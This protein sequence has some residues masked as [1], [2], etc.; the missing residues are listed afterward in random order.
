MNE[1]VHSPLNP[2]NDSIILDEGFIMSSVDNDKRISFFDEAVDKKYSPILRR[3][4]YNQRIKN[5]KEVLLQYKN[6][7]EQVP[8]LRYTFINPKMYQRKNVFVDLHYYYNIFSSKNMYKLDKS[9]DIYFDFICRLIENQSIKNEG[10]NKFSV[11]V[12]LYQNSWPVKEGTY[13]WDYKNN[14]NPLSVITRMMSRNPVKLKQEFSKYDWLFIGENGFFRIDFNTFD[15]KD[16]PR[17]KNAIKV[18]LSRETIIDDDPTESSPK[19]IAAEILDKFEDSQKVSIKKVTGDTEKLTPEDIETRVKAAAISSSN[20]KKKDALVDA[21]NKAAEDSKDID[22]AL[23]KL[24]KSID[25]KQLM[26]DLAEDDNDTSIVKTSATR[27]SRMTKLNDNF[28]NSQFKGRTIRDIIE[29]PKPQEL[30]KTSLKLDS[31]NPEWEDLKFINF[32]KTYD[33]DKD[34]MAIMASLGEKSVKVSIL[35]VETEDTS[36]SED[37]VM[38]YTFKC[39]DELGQ[40]FTLKYDIPKL[41]NN[42]FMRLRGNEKTISGQLMLLPAIKTAEDTVQLVSNYNKI[43]IRRFG[44]GA[45]KSFVIADK[46]I[47]ALNKYT[48]NDIKV[49]SGDNTKICSKYELPVDYID[50]ASVYSKIETN[51]CIIYFNQDEIRK[52]Y[53]DIIDTTKGIPIIYNKSN[54]IIVYYNPSLSEKDISISEFIGYFFE[55]INEFKE[56]YQSI[57]P[58]TKYTYSKASILGNNIPVIVLLGYQLGLTKAMDIANIKYEFVDKLTKDIRSS[59]HKDYIKFEDGYI[60]YDINYSSSMLMNGLKECDTADYSLADMNKRTTWF[61]F[62][63]EFGGR[64]LSDGLDN[65]ND[66]FVDPMTERICKR[67]DLPITYTDLL[68]YGSNL[69]ADNKYN[70][71][72]DI[73]GNRYRTN[74]IIAGY[75]YKMI[76]TAHGEYKSQIR[77]GRKVPMSVRRN[78]VIDFILKDNTSSDLSILNPLLEYETSNTV[79][80]KGL[81]GMNSDRSYGLDKRTYDDS[82]INVLALSTGFAANVGIN[83]WATIDMNIEGPEGFIRPGKKEEMSVTK[84][85]SMTEAL[86]PFGTTSDDPF[87]SAMTFIQTSKHEMRTNIAM[88]QLITTGADEALPYLTSD[89]FAFKAKDNGAIKEVTDDYIIIEYNDGNKDFIDIRERVMKNSDGGFYVTLKLDPNKKYKIGDKIKKGDIVAYD[90]HSYSKIVGNSNNLAYNIGTLAKVAILTTDEGYEDSTKISDWLSNAMS[91]EVVVTDTRIVPKDSNVFYIAK[92]GQEVQEG[93]PIFIF[94][95]AFDEEDINT[96][97]KNVRDDDDVEMV[98]ELGK[99]IIKSKVTGIIQDIHVYR[100]VELDEL[101]TSLRKVVKDIEDPI[102]KMKKV[103]KQNGIEDANSI[104]PTYKLDPTGKLKGAKNSVYFEFYLKYNDKL[105]VGDKVVCNSAAKGVCKGLFPKGD[106]PTSEYRPDEPIHILFA[107]GSFDA[108]MIGSVIKQASIN[109]VLIELDRHIKEHCGIEFKYLEDL[110]K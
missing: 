57:K 90:P 79:S 41:K 84:S 89:T 45:G 19:G 14:I 52:K 34:I 60:V 67:Y 21:V 58:A 30:P 1:S 88:P 28:A 40:R 24:D 27:T 8:F 86:T 102:N 73:T 20:E 15:L 56:I 23:D 91:S 48:G 94:Q 16:I 110:E 69:L 68:V 92:A 51:Q 54:K 36:T 66:W 62:L 61:N 11:F 5:N 7:K 10:Y 99:I 65:F 46:I 22:Q 109:K 38:T 97:L 6:M 29:S 74:E 49:T 31:I 44:S 63:D 26:I 71:H 12:P 35:S 13:I 83:R 43:F 70:R 42:R 4:L 37:Y 55:E 9:I 72:T 2:Y 18:L 64:I 78:T 77:R 75:T 80:F 47:K 25:L 104:E 33:I 106:E 85:L 32:N 39:E 105:G 76:S 59:F 82:M 81:A 17:F 3:Y 103:M 101:S 87:R 95:H 53:K 96:L 50:L 98:S 100:T 93:D 108:R 107:N